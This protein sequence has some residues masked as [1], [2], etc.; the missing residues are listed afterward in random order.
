MREHC[1]I[2]SAPWLFGF[3]LPLWM[4]N[5]VPTF[6]GGRELGS[7]SSSTG[8]LLGLFGVWKETTYSCQASKSMYSGVV[9]FHFTQ[10][11]TPFSRSG[12]SFDWKNANCSTICEFWSSLKH[13]HSSWSWCLV[14]CKSNPKS[15]RKLQMQ[16]KEWEGEHGYLLYRQIEIPL[17]TDLRKFGEEIALQSSKLR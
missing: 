5:P 6:K 3:P 2:R 9:A 15:Q 12:S 4:W 13:Q 17:G 1:C 11:W 10:V 16:L 7:G 8:I 14:P